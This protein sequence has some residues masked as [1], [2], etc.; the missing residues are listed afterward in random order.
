MDL[1][2]EP[3]RRDHRHVPVSWLS[4]IWQMHCSYPRPQKRR[5]GQRG[6]AASGSYQPTAPQWRYRLHR[7]IRGIS[8]C[9]NHRRSGETHVGAGGITEDLA[10]AGEG[11]K[12]DADRTATELSLLQTRQLAARERQLVASTRL[13]RVLSIPM[14]SSLLPQDTVAVP[15]EMMTQAADEA[16]LIST[17]LASRPELKE[18]QAL[19]AAACEAFKREKYAPFVPSV[20]LGFSTTSFGGGRGSNADNFSGRYDVDAMMVWEMRGSRLWRRC[21]SSRAKCACAASHLRKTKGYGPG[22]PRGG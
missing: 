1:A 11:L 18:S 13:A 4:S 12:S 19:V 7:S 16:S 21:G 10:E 22:R 15:L 3:L 17:G 9:R 14:S 2:L 5:R 6:H 8:R 20:L